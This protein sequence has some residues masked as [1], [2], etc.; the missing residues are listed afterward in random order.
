M[1]YFSE[2]CLARFPLG[3]CLGLRGVRFSR[4]LSVGSWTHIIERPQAGRDDVYPEL[5]RMEKHNARSWSN[6]KTR[7]RKD[8]GLSVVF[9]G[10]PAKL[11]ISC[12][13]PRLHLPH[14]SQSTPYILFERLKIPTTDPFKLARNATWYMTVGQRT[15]RPP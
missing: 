7:R 8:I 14:I 15:A 2:A 1:V 11:G 6:A 13:G 10:I 12:D 9:R 5:P 4:D 3:M